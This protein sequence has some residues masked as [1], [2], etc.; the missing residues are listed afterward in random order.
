MNDPEA[1]VLMQSNLKRSTKPEHKPASTS[2]SSGTQGKTKPITRVIQ[3]KEHT[4]V[5]ES[6]DRYLKVFLFHI[7]SYYFIFKTTAR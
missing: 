2:T 5:F 7:I 6:L 4:K 1:M 3:Q